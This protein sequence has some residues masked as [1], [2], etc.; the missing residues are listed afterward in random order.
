MLTRFLAFLASYWRDVLNVLG[1]SVTLFSVWLA[2][3]QSKM[4]TTAAEAAEE[5]AE[6]AASEARVSFRRYSLGSA[7]LVLEAVKHHLA[8][9]EWGSLTI[10]L[11]D[12][13]TYFSH[14]TDARGRSQD[15]RIE[16]RKWEMIFRRLATSDRKSY[17]IRKWSEFLSQVQTFLDEATVPFADPHED[18]P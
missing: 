7:V 11:G 3:R 10:R 5:A 15:M 16:A 4:A 1:L 9:E 8:S 17:P 12:L 2:Y 6:R 18:Q 13:A 14:L